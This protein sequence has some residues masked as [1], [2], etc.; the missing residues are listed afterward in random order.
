MGAPWLGAR[1][2][3]A[4]GALGLVLHYLNSAMLETSL[5]QIF[6]LIPATVSR[7]LQFGQQILLK[8]VR[9]MP[10]GQITFPRQLKEY[11]ENEALILGRHTRLVGAFGSID[12]LGLLAQESVDAEMENATYNGWKSGHYINNI[13][14]FS[15]QG[16]IFSILFLS[17]MLM[18]AQA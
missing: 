3:D 17:K 2:L 18:I 13:L 4:A 10:E 15:P 7:Y 6:A 11:Q 14:A 1:S 5:Q 8:T 16:S 12:G 9:T